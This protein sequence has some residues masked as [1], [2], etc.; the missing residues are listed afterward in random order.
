MKDNVQTISYSNKLTHIEQ[1]TANVMRAA[2]GKSA[3]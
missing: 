2:A 1:N 3:T